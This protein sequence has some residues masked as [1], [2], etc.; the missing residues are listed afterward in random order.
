MNNSAYGGFIVSKNVLNGV[1]ILYTYRE[2]SSIAQLNGW[3]VLSSQDDQA[4][5]GNA[6]NFAV[7]TAE[8]LFR[9][10]PVFDEIYDAPYGTDLMW[11]YEKGVHVGFY[12]LLTQKETTIREIVRGK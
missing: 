10:A 9:I 6:D 4:Y 11:L 7:V 3:N 1:P 12:N 5:L 2:K 8:T